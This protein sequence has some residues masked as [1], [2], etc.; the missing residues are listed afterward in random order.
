[1][2]SVPVSVPS[3]SVE[4]SVVL[5]L[6]VAAAPTQVSRRYTCLPAGAPS[7]RFVAAEL[8]ATYR[9]S[10]LIAAEWLSAFPAEPSAV[11]DTICVFGVHP[12]AA[13]TQV[14]RTIICAMSS[15]EDVNAT[16]RPSWLTVGV[17]SATALAADVAAAA[18]APTVNV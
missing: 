5:G 1:M 12:F 6:Q 13:P 8:N 10:T 18:P 9:P 17:S 2:L 3:V 14:S 15:C 7:T 4:I 16:Y 11:D